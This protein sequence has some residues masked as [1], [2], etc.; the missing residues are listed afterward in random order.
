MLDKI[1]ILLGT[2]DCKAVFKD[3]QKEVIENYRQLLGKIQSY[4]QG[5]V[6]PQIVMV[7]PPPYGPDEQLAEKY[8]GAGKRVKQLKTAFQ[9]LAEEEG[10]AFLDIQSPL[11]AVFEYISPDGVHLTEEGQM[12]IARIINSSF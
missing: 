5:K 1:I 4:Y 8:E 7:S 11:D 3:R 12:I 10:H 9:Q 2:N 6:M